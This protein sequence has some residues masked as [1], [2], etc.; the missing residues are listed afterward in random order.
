MKKTQR[1]LT[2]YLALTANLVIA[3]EGLDPS[4][5]CLLEPSKEIEVS[6]PVAGV[7]DKVYVTRGQRVTAGELLFSLRSEIEEAVLLV[8]KEKAAF[9][10]RTLK[11]NEDMYNENLISMHEKDEF[12]TD[13]TLADLAEIE[14]EVRLALKNVKSPISGYV[15]DTFFSEGEFVDERPVIKL[16]NIDLLHVEVVAPVSYLGTI[17]E[18]M[19]AL[20][21]PE[22]P[23]NE[24]YLARVAIVDPVVD[25]GS[26][27]FRIRL[28]MNNEMGV[29]SGLA[30]RVR[31]EP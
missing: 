6:S 4:L 13:S 22:K 21:A 15:V 26:G 20:V 3:E 17:E 24:S 18:G 7:V 12:E 23:I 19:S 1:A 31:I 8:A 9:G 14:A 29:P 28:E 5:G 30:C 10:K 2:L 27:T 25:A 16:V 11:R